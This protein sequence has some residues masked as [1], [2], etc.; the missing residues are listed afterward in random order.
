M[1]ELKLK[2][3]VKWKYSWTNENSIQTKLNYYLTKTNLYYEKI[4]Y[5]TNPVA[6][7]GRELMGG[8]KHL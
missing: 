2:N 3:M 1:Y 5:N 6:L 8:G 4:V 7:M